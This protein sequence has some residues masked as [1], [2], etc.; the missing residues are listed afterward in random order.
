MTASARSDW[1][2]LDLDWALW[3][4]ERDGL[5]YRILDSGARRLTP[6][7][8][9]DIMMRYA[10][11]SP[12]REPVVTISHFELASEPHVGL[13]I[14]EL[15]GDQDRYGRDIATVR[16]F[17]LPFRRLSEQPVSYEDL[18]DALR[19]VR[20][21]TEGSLRVDVPP[22]DPHYIAA[23]I[24]PATMSA[25]A[26]LMNGERIR[27]LDAE[28]VPLRERL[29]YLDTVAG[30]LPFG[31][32]A[33]FSAATWVS[34]TI[35]PVF[36]ISFAEFSED[37]FTT[38]YFEGGAPTL[39]PSS[40]GGAYTAI[41]R[42]VGPFSDL[43]DLLARA[44]EPLRFT[45]E[46]RFKALGI[47]SAARGP[48]PD[49]PAADLILSS[50][51]EALDQGNLFYLEH[52]L[53]EL[54][55]TTTNRPPAGAERAN[56]LRLVERDRLLVE[57][58]VPPRLTARLLDALLAGVCGPRLTS[59]E[60][61]DITRAAG[62][63]HP[64][65][66]DA[67]LRRP[68]IAPS[69]I[70]ALAHQQGPSRLSDVIARMPAQDLVEAAAEPPPQRWLIGPVCAALR[71]RPAEAEPALRH[72][73]YL[74]EELAAV[75]PGRGDIQVKN[76]INLLGAC[77]GPKLTPEQFDMILGGGSTLPSPALLGA[78]LRMYGPGGGERL[79]TVTL[80]GIFADAGF[81][82]ET[83]D[84]LLHTLRQVR[85]SRLPRRGPR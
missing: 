46:D 4:K 15:S 10:T 20:L 29:R 51:V 80:A 8:F 77:Y 12:T 42:E 35:R 13:A 49:A 64:A 76:L 55:L 39:M 6:K 58:R 56:L 16:Y 37:D 79:L 34:S 7:H 83:L 36:R 31:M 43:V 53:T 44:D 59:D 2:K 48:Q 70:L 54:F 60:L 5:D 50:C 17:C 14:Q 66:I 26:R 24:D 33:R 19:A 1:V 63:L 21:P 61:A 28:V 52:L 85:T 9:A 81:D 40:T 69:A 74:S 30:L 57:D 65:L 11:G 45:P 32:R 73:R 3:G 62:G 82:D 41:L 18:F 38:V 23:R 84:D 22:L 68:N 78:V 47:V 71:R 72:H 25:A 67:L 27:V 75:Y